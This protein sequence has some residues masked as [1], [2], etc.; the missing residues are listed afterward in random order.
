MDKKI[1]VTGGTGFIGS[2][3]CVSLVNA[4]FIPVILD[5]LCNS[6]PSVIER[7]ERIT[8]IRP[9]FVEGDIRDRILLEK[10]F[11][12]HD[13]AA[14]IHLAGLKAVGESVK[15]PIA[16]YENNVW[17]TLN[18]LQAMGE[19]HVKTFVFSS[20]A[21][22]YGEPRSMPIREDFPRSAF[23]PY[24]R[25]KLM[26]EDILEDLH[27]AEPGWNIARLRYFNP[28]GAHES[29][30]IGENPTGIPNN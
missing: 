13:I 5:N 4:G 24:G 9:E 29:G 7:L 17:G 1:L 20:S 26:V 18:L 25:S 11:S 30:L 21:T 8:G 15:L 6:E 10:I 2:H 22:V 3:T 14:V 23:N 27:H 19:A 16:Y 28:V 12:Q